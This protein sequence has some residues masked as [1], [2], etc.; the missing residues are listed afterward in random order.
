MG[1]VMGYGWYKLI[2]GMREAKYVI[3]LLAGHASTTKHAGNLQTP[4]TTIALTENNDMELN[5]NSY[6]RIGP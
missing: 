4:T 5:T 2:G 1:A 6:Q 3:S